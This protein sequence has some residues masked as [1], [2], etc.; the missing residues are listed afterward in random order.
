MLRILVASLV[1]LAVVPAWSQQ[2]P[3]PDEAAQNA[4]LALI[5]EAYKPD[6]EAAKTPAQRIAIAKKM[7]QQAMALRSDPTNQYLLLR[8][9]HDLAGKEGDIATAYTAIAIVQKVFQ[10][11]ALQLKAAVLADA[12]KALR[13]ANEQQRIIPSALALVGE[14]IVADKYEVAKTLG[15]LALDS[16]RRAKNTDLIKQ[17]V[18]RNEEV[19]HIAEA[20]AQSLAAREVLNDKPTDPAANLAV[21]KFNCFAKGDWVTGIPMLALGNDDELKQLAAQE[22]VPPEEVL[23]L[24]DGWWSIADQQDEVAAQR[25]RLH[26]VHWYKKAVPA[27]SGLSKA[28]I[29]KRI[30]D[31]TESDFLVASREVAA[32]KVFEPSHVPPTSDRVAFV[33]QGDWQ[34][35]WRLC[36]DELV[37]DKVG[38]GMLLFGDSRWTDYDVS[39]EM[40]TIAGMPNTPGG[41]LAFRATSMDSFYLFT[42]GNFGGT[43]MDLEKGQ[44]GKGYRFP[45]QQHRAPLML[46]YW[47][48]MR[49]EVRGAVIRCFA[50]GIEI[51]KYTD[52]SLPQGMVG[53][54]TFNSRVKWRNLTVKA[55][56]GTLL[57]EGFPDVSNLGTHN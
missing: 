39:V 38:K 1:T 29:E 50:D 33:G 56:D 15:E 57:W 17:V 6:F 55:P 47:Y 42:I 24:G 16:A 4:A 22:L 10:V 37:Q 7:L 5:T 31:A 36:G 45:G 18:R 23:A 21:G 44:N 11:D 43:V 49:V 51:F 12:A 8:T 3:V 19:D 9:A 2:I 54:Q 13:P 20:Y 35:D 48:S 52:D 26:A 25:V 14:A 41:S 40:F 34:G 30:S 32:Y 53:F 28:K 46:E 27:L